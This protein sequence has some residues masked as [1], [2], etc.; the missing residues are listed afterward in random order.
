MTDEFA[1]AK[2][3][4]R[5]RP[6]GKRSRVS[7]THSGRLCERLQASPP[8]I[9]AL[10]RAVVE[11]ASGCGASQCQREDIAIAVSEALTNVVQHAY[12][13]RD[14][15]GSVAVEAFVRGRELEG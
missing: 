12:A 14:S 8:S 5:R 4:Y 2:D 6:A 15:P 13:G 3:G 9:G 7:V 1:R 10:R 11:F